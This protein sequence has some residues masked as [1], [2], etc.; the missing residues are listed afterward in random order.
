MYVRLVRPPHSYRYNCLDI[1][2]DAILSYL[3]GYFD[4]I[5]FADYDAFDFHLQRELHFDQLLE[6]PCSDYVISVRETGDNVHYAL[7]LAQAL[8]ERTSSQVWLYGQTARLGNLNDASDGF[9]TVIHSETLMA[10]K[11]GL[12]STGPR[13]ESGLRLRPLIDELASEPWQQ[14]RRKASIETTRGC[15]FPCEFCFINA[16]PNYDKR[17]VMRQ[18]ADVIADVKAYQG[19]GIQDIVF[20]DSEFFGADARQYP[21]KVELLNQLVSEC[22][23]VRFKIY[24]RADTL[25]KFGNIDL[26]KRAGLVSVFIGVESLYEPDLVALKKKESPETIYQAI[27]ALRDAGIYT[28]LSFILFNRATTTESLRYNLQRISTLLNENRRFIGM[29]YFSFSFES[30]WK[31]HSERNELSDRTYVATDVAMKSPASGGPCFDAAFEPLMEIYRLLAYEWSKKVTQLNL[32]RDTLPESGQESIA[33]WFANLSTFCVQVMC[34]F[35]DKFEDGELT[36]NSL[37]RER[38]SLFEAV[39]AYYSVLPEDLRGL[40]TH[41]KH[42]LQLSYANSSSLL[43]LDEYWEDAIPF[44]RGLVAV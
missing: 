21:Q 17:W 13:F 38:D 1:R 5:G 30:G 15:H 37:P 26:L 27:E 19:L 9:P 3:A 32:S 35:L 23:G 18:P 12:S 24:A 40:A 11:L 4:A 33:L 42:A 28:D 36:L 43:E 6:T 44:S 22:G 39:A 2:E 14:T 8:K 16:G 41:S 7:R 31:P 10:T 34:S 20:N 25:L 29:P